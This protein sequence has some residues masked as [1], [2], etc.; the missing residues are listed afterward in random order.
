MLNKGG[1]EKKVEISATTLSEAFTNISQTMGDDFKRRVLNADGTP[2]SLI[3]IYINGKNTKFFE[4][5]ET[6]LNDG[7]EI[8]I[9]PAVAGGSE[10]SNKDLDRYS[11]QVML[12]E[13]GY[14]GQLKLKTAKICV[15]G[16]G[17]LGN[18]IIT[19]L[20]AMGVGKIR[21]VDRD[22]I[23]SSNLHRQTMF[24]DS[25]VGEI[26]VE[27]AEK[28]LRKL[29]PD[30]QIDALP[31]SVNDYNA[32]EVVDGCDVVIDALDSVNARYAL[33]KA[34]VAKDTPFV[35]GA[36]VGAFGQ[37][38]T[39]LPKQSAC[40]HCIFPALDEDSMPTCSIEG[41]HPSILSIIGGIEV[42][43]AVRIIMGKKP[44]LSE[45]ILHIDLENL[46]FS[47]T[48][49]FKVDECFVCGIGKVVTSV[50]EELILEELC[51][52]N[53]GKRTF[54][55]TPT[56]SFEIDMDRITSVARE[57]GFLTE[58][59]GD[60]GLSVRNNAFSVSF[61]KRGSSVVVGPKN[62]DEA[63]SLYKKLLKIKQ[64]ISEKTEHKWNT[65]S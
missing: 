51:G 65:S 57:N 17:G 38:F 5:M 41:V 9:L 24:D 11:R 19:I 22:I 18:P 2:R 4:G 10:L 16:V 61:M 30:V 39:V 21:I 36:A 3:N 54:S 8:Y 23:E 52:R 6:T 56:N 50:K 12:D 29:N 40:Y 45:R 53:R 42:S 48:K 43:E 44:N 32:I 31:I 59:Q 33:N 62:A 26:K 1:G 13:I 58:N 34:C 14:Q 20:V 49:T 55:I 25:D 47:Y 63:I 28:K 46:D 7:D 27:V 37:A 35:T 64:I 60:L 15:V